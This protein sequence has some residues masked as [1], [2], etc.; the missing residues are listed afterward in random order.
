MR[1]EDHPAPGSLS[2]NAA[3]TALVQSEG[4]EASGPQTIE[5]ALG[6]GPTEKTGLAWTDGAGLATHLT[7]S[8]DRTPR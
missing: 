4:A 5:T 3:S 6:L 2:R 1:M 8:D 7:P